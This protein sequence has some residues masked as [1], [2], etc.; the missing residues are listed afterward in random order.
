MVL[1]ASTNTL[2]VT[3]EGVTPFIPAFIAVTVTTLTQVIDMTTKYQRNQGY[4]PERIFRNLV[5]M[6]LFVVALLDA[7]LY[8]L[9]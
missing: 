6:G 8:Y 2:V 3:Q 9:R 7:I 1:H 5:V 4:H